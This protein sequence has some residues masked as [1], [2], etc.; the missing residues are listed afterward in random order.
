MKRPPR[1]GIVKMVIMVPKEL[2]DAMQQIWHKSGLT[3]SQQARHSLS[4]WVQSHSKDPMRADA[5][6]AAREL[7]AGKTKVPMGV[8]QIPPPQ[9]IDPAN[10]PEPDPQTDPGGWA[11]WSA[12]QGNQAIANLAKGFWPKGPSEPQ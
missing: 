3:I 4:L 12:R 2:R 11:S 8:P 6:I 10:D 9:P 5:R 1:P 7:R